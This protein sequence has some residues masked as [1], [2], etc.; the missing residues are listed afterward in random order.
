[1]ALT[2]INIPEMEIVLRPSQT[3]LVAGD[4]FKLVLHDLPKDDALTLT[5]KMKNVSSWNKSFTFFELNFNTP[6]ENQKY[7]VGVTLIY[8]GGL[9]GP[10]Q[11]FVIPL[12][13][14]E[15]N[16]LVVNLKIPQEKIYLFTK[17][18]VEKPQVSL[19]ETNYESS[20]LWNFWRLQKEWITGGAV[21]SIVLVSGL[22]LFL[23]NRWRKKRQQKKEIQF[24]KTLLASDGGRKELE[25]I[26]QLRN[27]WMPKVEAG[28]AD[29]FLQEMDTIQY[30]PSWSDTD[31]KRIQSTLLRLRETFRG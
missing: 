9:E 6:K 31:L 20:P 25:K 30:A 11:Q 17:D 1:M 7:D 5:S 28:A 12:S 19:M 29:K 22:I 15:Q 24:L 16:F 23:L 3:T 4:A 2:T 18:V 13:K 10:D 26:Y 27:R 21:V 14:K 8:R